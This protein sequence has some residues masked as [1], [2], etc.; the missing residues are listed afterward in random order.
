MARTS[1]R[2]L[3]MRRLLAL[4]AVY[5]VIWE[6]MLVRDSNHNY[7][8]CP[9]DIKHLVWKTI[10]YK[11]PHRPDLNLPGKRTLLN[12]PGSRF[13]LM[14]E[15]LAQSLLQSIVKALCLSQFVTGK[16]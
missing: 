15:R 13:R 1:A 14:L 8:L 9:D 7:P 11:T 2:V 16:R 3:G 5:P 4:D 6:T 12:Q 10:Q